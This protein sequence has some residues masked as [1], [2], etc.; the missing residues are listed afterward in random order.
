[1]RGQLFRYLLGRRRRSETGDH[2]TRPIN[3]K[4]GKIPRNI[5]FTFLVR[6]FGFQEIVE[7]AGTVA[8]DLDLGEQGEG[9][10]V[11]GLSEFEDFSVRARFLCAELVT[12]EAENGK[13][14]VFVAFV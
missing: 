9:D 8:I 13:P 10:I 3:K 2:R 14:V 11:F 12:G 4:F 5:V 7:I 6:L 1:M